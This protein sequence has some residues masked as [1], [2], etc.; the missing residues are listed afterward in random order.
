MNNG[1]IDTAASQELS[2][3]FVHL[4]FHVYQQRNALFDKRLSTINAILNIY[5]RLIVRLAE[6]V[7]LVHMLNFKRPMGSRNSCKKNTSFLYSTFIKHKEKCCFLLL[8]LCILTFPI[9]GKY[10][11]KIRTKTWHI[12]VIPP[13]T[14]PVTNLLLGNSCVFNETPSHNS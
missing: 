14:L 13:D 9:H 5:P 6:K 8:L 3:S 10:T 7:Q 4:N 11:A 2:A 12:E 1:N